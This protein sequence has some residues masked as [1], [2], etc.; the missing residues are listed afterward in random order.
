MPDHRLDPRG[1]H[2][3]PGLKFHDCAA[4]VGRDLGA[5]LALGDVEAHIAGALPRRVAYHDGVLAS[6]EAL[7]AAFP[8][9]LGPNVP[10]DDTI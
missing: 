9:E 1:S 4:S 8:P 3:C 7:R 5:A 2:S 10:D 6:R